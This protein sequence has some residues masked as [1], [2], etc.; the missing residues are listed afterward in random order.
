MGWLFRKT[1]SNGVPAMP[2]HLT[3]EEREVIAQRRSAGRRQVE[4]AR[5]LE[6]AAGT[7][8]RELQR[9]RSGK[10]FAEHRQWQP[11]LR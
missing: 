3:P 6:R 4:I 8:S 1:L 7:I 10:D 9:N 2:H 5:Q 11:K